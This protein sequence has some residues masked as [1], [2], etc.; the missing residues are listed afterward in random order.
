MY[1][2]SPTTRKRKKEDCVPHVLEAVKML[3]DGKDH[4]ASTQNIVK[5][6]ERKLNDET[7]GAKKNLPSPVDTAVKSAIRTALNSGLLVHCSGVGLNGSFILPTKSK[8]TVATGNIHYDKQKSVLTKEAKLRKISSLANEFHE[9][10]TLQNKAAKIENSS[11]RQRNTKL[12]LPS[13]D[14][15]IERDD[16]FEAAVKTTALK[17]I[18]KAPGKRKFTSKYK[19]KSVSRKRV[20][21][22]SPPR[23]I[24]ITPCIKRRSKSKRKK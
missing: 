3:A 12:L 1:K 21:F 24:F 20:K 16:Q 8:E 22:C 6:L 5:Y 23:V 17:T 14:L 9:K 10:T 18:L 11:K 15:E 13:G 4:G 7:N 19:R 2:M